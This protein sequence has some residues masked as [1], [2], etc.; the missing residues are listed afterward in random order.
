MEQLQSS[1]QVVATAKD[2]LKSCPTARYLLV[3]QPNLNAAHLRSSGAAPNLYRSL[4]KAESQFSV[5]EVAGH[6]DVEELSSYIRE[7]CSGKSASVEKVGLE[8]LTATSS[9]SALNENGT[10][11]FAR[12]SPA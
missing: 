11:C 5:A 1:S 10:R 12:Y 8:A 3:E 6:L 7:A 2:L 9:F 4:E